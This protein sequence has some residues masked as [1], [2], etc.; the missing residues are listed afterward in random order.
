MSIMA[1]KKQ[2]LYYKTYIE[3]IKNLKNLIMLKNIEEKKKVSW[4]HAKNKCKK[5]MKN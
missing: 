1:N 4:L 3:M 5:D 2:Q